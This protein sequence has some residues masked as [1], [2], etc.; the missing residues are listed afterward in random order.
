MI[1]LPNL[2]NWLLENILWMFIVFLIVE[3]ILWYL[4][5]SLLALFEQAKDFFLKNPEFILLLLIGMIIFSA[6][7]SETQKFWVF[8]LIRIANGMAHLHARS[9]W[10]WV[11]LA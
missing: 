8:P 5:T 3:L 11:L 10:L 1:S 9:Y 6:F 2:Y 7:I 4:E